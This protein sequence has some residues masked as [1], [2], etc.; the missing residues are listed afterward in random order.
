MFIKILAFG[1]KNYVRD[2]F[3][4]FDI[5]VIL[6]SIVDVVL[7]SNDTPQLQRALVA[8]RAFRFLRIFK[9]AR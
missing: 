6:F 4:I 1:P 8:F 9:I 7:T 5:V 2:S 3:N